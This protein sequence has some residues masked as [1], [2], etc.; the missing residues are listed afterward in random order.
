MTWHTLIDPAFSGRLCLTLMH[1]IWQVSLLALVVWSLDRFWRNASVERRYT[2]HVIALVTAL[3]AVPV[4]YQLLHRVEPVRNTSGESPVRMIY[5]KPQPTSLSNTPVKIERIDSRETLTSESQTQQVRQIQPTDVT[6]TLLVPPTTLNPPTQWLWLAPWIMAIYAAGVALMLTRL[7]IASIRANRLGSQAVLISEG[8]LVEALR[9][10]AQQWSMKVVPALARAEQIVVPKVIGI[11]RPTILLPASTIS[12]LT[13]EELELILAHELAHVRRYDM[14][15]YLLQR[16]AEAILFFNPPLWYLSRRISVLREFCCDEMACQTPS[17]SA[18][19]SAFESRVEYATALLRIA[20]LAKRNSTTTPDL[21]SLAASGK[22][23]SEMRQ[24][25]ARLFG[26]PLREPLRVSRTGVLALLALTLA[27]PLVSL[28]STSTAQTVT[29]KEEPA[30]KTVTQKTPPPTNNTSKA[31]EDSRTF[32]LNVVDSAGK[33]VPNALIEARTDPAVTPEQIQRG[34][35]VRKSTYGPYVRTD[36]K[37]VLQLTVPTRLKRFNLNIKQPGYGPYWATWSL[38]PHRDPIP[39]EFTA[40]LDKAWTVGG[41]VVDEAGKPIA[42]ARVSPSLKFKKRPSDSSELGVGTRITTDA[43]GQWRYPHIP[44]S[45]S[46]VY[47]AVNHP[48]YRAWRNRIARSEFTVKK[49][50]KPTGRIVLD[51]GLTIVGVVADEQGNPILGALVRTKFANEIRK[52]TTDENGV[53]ILS[54]C[55]PRMAR[56]VVSANGRALELQEVRVDPEMEPVDFILKPGGKIRVR[57]V[58]E[59]GKGVPK[60]RIFFQRWRGHIQYFEFD[61]ISQYADENG[62]WEWNEAPLD[63][64]Q[65]DICRTGGMQLTDQSLQAREEEYVFAPPKTLVISGKVIDAKT[66]QPVKKF[67]VTHGYPLDKEQS[68]IFWNTTDRFESLDGQYQLRINRDAPINKV[69]IEADGYQVA[70]SREIK[71]DE[72]NVSFDFALEPAEDI[73]SH[74]Q[75][76]T[77]KPAADAEITIGIAGTQIAIMNGKVR[78]LSTY[79]TTVHADADGLFNIPPR[80]ESFQLVITHPTGFAYLSSENGKLPNPIKLT[81]WARLEGTFRV[82]NQIAP[83]VTLSIQGNGIN[84]YEEDNPHIYTR[85]QVKTDQN[86]RYVFERVFPGNGYVGRN[87][88]FMVNEGATEVTSAIQIPQQFEAGKT[89]TLDLGRSGRPVIGKLVPPETFQ[90]KVIWPFATL[91]AYRY[92]EPPAIVS[93]MNTLQNDPVQ[94]QTWFD[95]WKQSPKYAEEKA[96]I[97][98]YQRANEKLRAETPHLV[99]TMDRDG[100]FRIDNTPPGTYSMSVYFYEGNQNPGPLIDHIFSVPPAE[101]NG[102][103]EPVDLGTLPLK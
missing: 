73:A 10:L 28:V 16:F 3:V 50:Q 30:K 37:G 95:N 19:S 40:Q 62:V 31:K 102:E 66:K 38:V 94:Y 101:K 33:P 48:E 69:R 7:I 84:V 96:A 88:T 68:H 9:S 80:Q 81:A 24:R 44:V 97:E 93:L 14:W 4:T 34:K 42:G 47:I 20:E 61:H 54:G 103:T 32:R 71:P 91:R 13:T 29:K 64:F 27:L 6:S 75:T 72:G 5:V 51:R 11:I 83:N 63:E 57:V 17:T 60:A 87:I 36:K 65:A 35:Y 26:E 22:S 99:A 85:N 39:T 52:A 49:N 59:Q 2:L 56:V 92:M 21:S 12:G 77:G 1:S 78:N 89:I 45:K 100:S 23:P 74:I 98:E 70:T 43:N 46:E 8:P 53:Y 76:P 79:A 90:G 18:S 82:A 41:T 15:I 58:D 86:G 25:V 55:E 67:H